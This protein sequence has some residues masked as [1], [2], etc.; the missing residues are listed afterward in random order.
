MLRNE[1]QGTEDSA[2]RKAMLAFV[3]CVAS[4]MAIAMS[5]GVSSVSAGDLGSLKVSGYISGA[6]SRGRAG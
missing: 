4:L 3:P 1:W 2:A 6:H 5:P